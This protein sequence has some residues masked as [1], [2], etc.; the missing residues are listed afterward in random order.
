MDADLDLGVRQARADERIR[1]S[2]CPRAMLC[3]TEEGDVPAGLGHSVALVEVD[4]ESG[5]RPPQQIGGDGR[6]TVGD[7]AK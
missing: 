6:R 4:V 3:R 1:V 5:D 7:L 2:G